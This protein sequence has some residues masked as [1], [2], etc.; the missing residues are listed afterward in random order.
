DIAVANSGTGD[1]TVRL[2]NGM[3][4]FPTTVS[5]AVGD[6]PTWVAIADFNGDG[7]LDMVSANARTAN[8][9]AVLLNN[10][11][12]PP[13]ISANLITRVA[14]DPSANSTVATVHDDEQAASTLS[15]KVN[16]NST[17]TV[18]GVTVSNITIDANG[19]VHAAVVAACG[20]TSAAFT[21]K[22][23]DDGGLSNTDT[24][25]V[26]VTP[27]VTLPSINCPKPITQPTDANQC[28]ATIKFSPTISDNCPVAPVACT[29]APASSFVKGTTTVNCTATDAANNT[30]N[31]SFT[32]TVVDMQPPSITC[33]API[34]RGTA[35]NA[36]TAM[37]TY[38]APTVSDN[39]AGVG[40]P[41][42]TPPSGS[43]FP[44]G[45]TDVTC[46]VSD[47]AN[48][49]SSCS[50][51]VTVNDTE[52]PAFVNGC[53]HSISVIAPQSCP[54]ATSQ[55]VTYQTPAISDNCPG[56][57][58][59]CAPPSGSTFAVG[60]TTVTCTASDSSG[61]TA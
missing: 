15:V 40:A 3:G 2:G 19:G 41:S 49:S 55:T 7:K 11:D 46:S 8:N 47:A 56:A 4:G 13:T 35:P 12:T 48:L 36:C 30:A 53:P 6:F 57:T 61:N 26:T 28:T 42:C 52:P 50:F 37:V 54:L 5:F 32:V 34:V 29:P 25:N 18:N 16:N 14:G 23:T 10:C 45:I 59:A 60:T 22:V 17:A 20:A 39:C 1:V 58:V 51:I 24:L 43:T 9:A 31:C 27:D 44:K 33:P 21:L 38:A